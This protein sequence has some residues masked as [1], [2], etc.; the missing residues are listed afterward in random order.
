MVMVK[1]S[2][3][4]KIKGSFAILGA[5]LT[6]A[7]FGTLVHVLGAMFGP[8][9][10][11]VFRALLAALIMAGFMVFTRHRPMKLNHSDTL[12]TG[13]VGFCGS[14]TLGLFTVVAL[15]DKAASA[16]FLVF[17]GAILT[18][19]LGGMIFL[20]ERV[21]II[22]IA[23]LILVVSGLLLYA[24]GFTYKGLITFAGLLGGISDGVAN[25]LR[26]Q[27]RHLDRPTVVAYQY[28][29]GAVVAALY[30]LLSHEQPILQVTILPILVMIA[31]AVLALAL[32]TFL[33]YGYAHVDLQTGAILSAMQIFF[34]IILGAIFLHQMPTNNEIV[35]CFLIGTASCL[36]VLDMRKAILSI[37]RSLGWRTRT[38]IEI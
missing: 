17:A 15:H 37:K 28:G 6:I 33:L 21:T 19:L 2:L 4:L 7:L 26:K 30:V 12:K 20:G 34:A 16:T 32:G 14:L 35:G 22:R 9:T 10:Q 31:F 27:M 36:A 5:S 8:I 25:I 18:S 1:I 3:P 29:V 11:T 13:L 23:A 24:H 38:E